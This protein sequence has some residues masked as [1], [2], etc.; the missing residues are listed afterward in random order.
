MGAAPTLLAPYQFRLPRAYSRPLP[1][2]PSGDLPR[3]K[4]RFQKLP[5]KHLRPKVC[6][7]RSLEANGGIRPSHR[8]M[9]R[10]EY[11]DFST[12]T[13]TQ[14]RQRSLPSRLERE[15]PHFTQGE[16]E[17]RRS[18]AAAVKTK[19]KAVNTIGTSSKILAEFGHL[20]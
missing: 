15:Q 10:V 12:G 9:L 18:K 17:R 19:T 6:T 8:A 2:A 13:F 7:V 20:G 3:G 1:P 5:D 16:R 11:C 4:S 14:R